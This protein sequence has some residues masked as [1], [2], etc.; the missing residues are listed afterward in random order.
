MSCHK[1]VMTT[2]YITLSARTSNVITMSV[3]TKQIFIDIIKLALAGL[4]NF[5]GNDHSCKILYTYICDIK[6]PI[7]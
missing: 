4:M 7:F 3:T 5:I 1:N 6:V 2:Q